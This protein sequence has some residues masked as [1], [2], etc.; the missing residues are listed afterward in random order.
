M[1][2]RMMLRRR[3]EKQ[4][5]DSSNLIKENLLADLDSQA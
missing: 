1:G 4:T 3:V 2:Q 5:L